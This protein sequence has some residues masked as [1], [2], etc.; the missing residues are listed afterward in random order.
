MANIYRNSIDRWFERVFKNDAQ[1]YR[2]MAGIFS[3]LGSADGD[4]FDLMTNTA[5]EVQ[6]SA[7][8]T[9]ALV[10]QDKKQEARAQVLASAGALNALRVRINELL[11]KLYGLRAEFIAIARV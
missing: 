2:D 3:R 6:I 11:A 4:M 7:D 1:A 9:L 5:R 8:Q 10:G